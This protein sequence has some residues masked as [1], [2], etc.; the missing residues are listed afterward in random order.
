ML[1]YFLKYEIHKSAKIGYAW[2]FPHK[3]IMDEGAY[4]GHL[5]VAINLDE[6]VMHTKSKIGRSNWITGFSTIKETKF[7]KHQIGRSSKLTLGKHSA[8]T[9]KH[10]IDCTNHINIGSY[11]TVAGYQSQ[12]LTHSIDVFDNRQ[13]SDPIFIGDYT[14]IGTNSVILGGARLPNYSLL[15]AKSML[16]KSFDEEWTI[17]GGVPAKP[18][19]NISKDAKYFSRIEGY[20]Y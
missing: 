7:F 11:A 16:G 4:I 3:L 19:G 14:F 17:Y 1:N 18:I 5:T 12:L 15:A 8:I 9:K 10:H 2:V 20:V 6:I 13:N